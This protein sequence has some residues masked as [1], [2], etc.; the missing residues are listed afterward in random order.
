MK[1]CADASQS[2]QQLRA[3]VENEKPARTVKLYNRRLQAHTIRRKRHFALVF[4]NIARSVFR[5]EPNWVYYTWMYVPLMTLV[6]C[7]S[8]K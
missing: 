3:L 2:F 7:K 8:V 4:N 6:I 5:V 1:L